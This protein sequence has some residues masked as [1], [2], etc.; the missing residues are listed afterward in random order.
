MQPNNPATLNDVFAALSRAKFFMLAGIIFGL[1]LA[2]AFLGL[3]I[4][5]YRAHMVV[6]PAVPIIYGERMSVAADIQAPVFDDTNAMNFT[7]FE[8]TVA[9][10]MVAGELLKDEKIFEGLLQDKTFE[11]IDSREHWT[12]QEFADYVRRRV[13]IEPVG[14][15]KLRRLVYY[16]PSAG[17][18]AY[19]LTRLSDTAD[20]LIRRSI[21]TEAEKRVQYL[22]ETSQTVLNPENRRSLTDLLMEQEKLMLLTSVNQPYAATVVEPA[23]SSPRPRWPSRFCVVAAFL[24]AGALAGLVAHGIRCK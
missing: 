21:R 24:F 11:F 22:Q 8:A 14:D 5:S 15:T 18:A 2:V 4:P 17:F 19:F 20:G 1:M 13:R 6:G 12:P 3:A 9:G 10:P 23:A 16:H 7:R